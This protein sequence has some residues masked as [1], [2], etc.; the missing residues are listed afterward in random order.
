MVKRMGI[1]VF[2]AA[3]CFVGFGNQAAA[4]QDGASNGDVGTYSSI[5]PPFITPGKDV[6]VT[7]EGE[8]FVAVVTATCF[9]EDDSEA[10][11]DFLSSSPDF[12]HVAGTY[13]K[14][15]IAN[16]YAEGIGVVYIT[17]QIGD[18]GKYFVSLQVKACSGKVER[19]ITFKVKVKQALMN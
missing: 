8:T 14:E 17:P 9:L 12:V 7:R 10:Q 4:G 18:A 2:L 5:A 15:N 6:F 19:V 16:G 1:L 11:F 13:R 3:T